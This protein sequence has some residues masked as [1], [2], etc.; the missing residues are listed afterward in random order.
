MIL[1]P[2]LDISLFFSAL[3]WHGTVKPRLLTHSNQMFSHR[4]VLLVFTI[5][6]TVRN[7]VIEP[8]LHF[9]KNSLKS[10]TLFKVQALELVYGNLLLPARTLEGNREGGRD[11]AIPFLSLAWILHPVLCLWQKRPWNSSGF[12]SAF[13]LP[14]LLKTGSS[15]VPHIS[16]EVMILSLQLLE[17]GITDTMMSLLGFI[18]FSDFTEQIK[19]CFLK[20]VSHLPSCF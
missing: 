20:L 15:C 19:I 4:S 1:L 11:R 18:F 12:L 16:S 5:P 10:L 17:C 6:N 7:K 13:L 2:V 14:S 3:G 8:L 9:G